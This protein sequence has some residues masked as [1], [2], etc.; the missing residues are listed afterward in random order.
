V[1]RGANPGRIRVLVADDHPIVREGIVALVSRQQEM[2][3]VA[4][5]SDGRQAIDLYRRERPDVALFD[6]R[7]P[8]TDG[9]AATIAVKNEFPDAR[10]VILTT[11]DNDEDIYSALRAGAQAYLLK[12]APR[13][14]L[15]TAIRNVVAGRRHIPP[16]VAARLAERVGVTDLTPRELEVLRQIVRG[17][18]NKEIGDTLIITEGTVKGHVNNILSKLGVTDRTQAALAAVRR[19]LVSLDE[20]QP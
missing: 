1:E 10:I 18:S 3:V 5:A 11:Y 20:A 8:I 6:L 13:E 2:A 9:V 7:M 19:G 15:L 12:D 17:K 16:H 4:E 14:E